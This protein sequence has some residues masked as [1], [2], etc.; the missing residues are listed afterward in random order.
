LLR[1]SIPYLENPSFGVFEKST[2]LLV[3]PII[4]TF[5]KTMSPK[6]SEEIGISSCPEIGSGLS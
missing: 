6:F 5:R 2:N 1:Y 4:S 3:S